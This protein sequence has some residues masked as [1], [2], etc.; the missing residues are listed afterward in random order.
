MAYTAAALARRRCAHVFGDGHARAGERCRA[1]ARWDVPGALDGAGLCTA[2]AGRVR[3]ED[4]R[5]TGR[6]PGSYECRT[7]P[8]CACAA[9]PFPHRPGGGLCRWPDPPRASLQPR[10]AYGDRLRNPPRAWRGYAAPERYTAPDVTPGDTP[11]R[12]SVSP[13]VS[14]VLTPARPSSAWLHDLA[15]AFGVRLPSV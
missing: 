12:A 1:F 7:V 10:T 14:G 2:H 6:R 13:T 8:K 15:R 11:P 5:G 4:R 9:Y 3:G